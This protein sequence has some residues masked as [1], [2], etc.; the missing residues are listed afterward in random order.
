MLRQANIDRLVSEGR[1]GA[2]GI[3][4]DRSLVQAGHA[5][6]RAACAVLSRFNLCDLRAAPQG[7]SSSSD[8]LPQP[9]PTGGERLQPLVQT[10]L[11]R[12]GALGLCHAPP[13]LCIE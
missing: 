2:M 13:G 4:D 12:W 6:S 10:D 1:I 8:P 5:E 3:E 11:R 7:R 9:E